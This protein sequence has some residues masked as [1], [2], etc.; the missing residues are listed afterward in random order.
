[1]GLFS[2]AAESAVNLVAAVGAFW[3]LVAA[4][5][6][7]DEEHAFGHTKA[8]YFSSALESVLI[9]AAA[10]GIGVTAIGRLLEPQP[11]ENV[12]LGLAISLVAAGINGGVGLVLLRSGRHLRSTALRADGHHLLTDVWT[13]AGVVAGVFLVWLTGW[14][15]L[16]PL[17]ALVVAGNIVWVGARLLNDTA[18]GLLDTALPPDEQEVVTDIQ[19][20]YEAEGVEFHATRTRTAGTRRFVSMHVLVPG[21]WSVKQAHDLSERIE[22]DIARALPMTTVFVHIEP[23]EDPV[24]WQDQDLDRPSEEKRS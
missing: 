16:D 7:P 3:A 20:R 10:V 8:E 14:L 9:I 2:D 5:R 17:I 18:H 13:S 23:L 21:E 24:S 1:M 11:L 6:P 19:S 12:G 22:T 4:A 15:V